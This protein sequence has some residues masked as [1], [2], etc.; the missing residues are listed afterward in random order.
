[1]YF[2][3]TPTHEKFKLYDNKKMLSKEPSWE[4]NITPFNKKVKKKKENQNYVFVK[5]IEIINT[6]E[7][8]F[9]LESENEL[10]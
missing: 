8:I 7:S 4:L 9:E 5:K 3:N 1:M 10:L 6:D 2:W